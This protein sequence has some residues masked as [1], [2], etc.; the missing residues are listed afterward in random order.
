[1]TS[2][3]WLRRGIGRPG[4]RA[5]NG[6]LIFLAFEH[7]FGSGNQIT[8]SSDVQLMVNERKM[9]ISKPSLLDFGLSSSWRNELRRNRIHW[10]HRRLLLQAIPPV[11]QWKKIIPFLEGFPFLHALMNF[12]CSQNTATTA[13]T[14]GDTS[15]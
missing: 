8:N 7:K 13:E 3:F 11:R 15:H 14:T 4:L 2:E 10:H 9:Q 6:E 5:G 12:T 1:L